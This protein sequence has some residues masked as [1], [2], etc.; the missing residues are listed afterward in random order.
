MINWIVAI[1]S[2]G[3][4]LTWHPDTRPPSVG[5]RLDL[6]ELMDLGCHL[7]GPIGRSW[8]Y[9]FSNFFGANRSRCH[10]TH[11]LNLFRSQFL[12][13]WHLWISI[14]GHGPKY[15]FPNLH[16]PAE[17]SPWSNLRFHPQNHDIQQITATNSAICSIHQLR[18]PGKH[19]WP[20]INSYS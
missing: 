2:L 19:Q 7:S 9:W 10:V 6:R 3:E 11:E 4:I 1:G 20:M 17:S 13:L 5:T 8:S 18:P 15:I 12:E 16:Q 14:R